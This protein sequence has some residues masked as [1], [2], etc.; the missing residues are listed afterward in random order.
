MSD[1]DQNK[2]QEHKDAGDRSPKVG[3]LLRASRLRVGEDLRDISDVL[4]IRY[5]YLEAI[6]DCRYADLPGNTYAVGFIRSY[7]EHLGLDGDEVVRRYRLEQTGQRNA[8]DLAFPTPVPDSGVP[9]GAIVFIGVL[10]ALLV[11]GGWY[12]TTTDESILSDLISPVPDHLKHL[13]TGDDAPNGTASGSGTEAPAATGKAAKKVEKVVRETTAAAEQMADA[14]DEAAQRTAEAAAEAAAT[15]SDAVNQAAETSSENVSESAGSAVPT[16]S[17]T[18]SAASTATEST[19]NAAAETNDAAATA[20]GVTGKVTQS[21]ET[22]ATPAETE[23]PD[24]TTEPMAQSGDTASTGENMSTSTETATAP[25]V[26]ESDAASAPTEPVAASGSTGTG[27]AATE[28]SGTTMASGTRDAVTSEPLAAPTQAPAADAATPETAPTESEPP[29]AASTSPEVTAEDLNTLVLRQATGSSGGTGDADTPAPPETASRT[30]GD[31]AG[32]SGIVIRA[33]SSSWVEIR[34][35]ANSTIVYT[36]LMSAGNSFNVP[37]TE[38]LVLDT[39][40]A[41]ALDI[42]VDGEP[43]P[44]IGGVGAVRKNVSLNASRLRAGTATNR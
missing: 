18:E 3:A 26:A 39:G 41:G 23:T 43:V 24:P 8:T 10:I 35:P 36:G 12:V 5:L 32:T 38:G 30:S 13:V 17:T 28:Q 37:D 11:Y 33:T 2:E 29:Q 1:T 14:A 22:A 44:K 34:D 31:A 25:A 15:A 20:T 19:A 16:E 7:A 6:E 4:C 40:N 9:K 21:A 42:S 27:T